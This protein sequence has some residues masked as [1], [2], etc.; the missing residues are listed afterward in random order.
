MNMDF[1]KVLPQNLS[2]RSEENHEKASRDS[3][4]PNRDLVL[5]P[6]E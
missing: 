2:R 3:Q 4:P 5:G 1:I 6:P